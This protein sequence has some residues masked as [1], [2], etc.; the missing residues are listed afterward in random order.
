MWILGFYRDF[1]TDF[2]IRSENIVRF[3][4]SVRRPCNKYHVD[5]ED[6]SLIRFVFVSV[7]LDVT[8]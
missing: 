1:F 8:Q 6:V 7:Q 4:A 3:Y 5:T 2:T